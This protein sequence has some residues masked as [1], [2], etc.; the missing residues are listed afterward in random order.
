MCVPFN[1]RTLFVASDTP[2]SPPDRRL[3]IL[4]AEDSATNQKL[5]TR[6]LR[7]INCDLSIVEN[8]VLAVDQFKTSDFDVVLMDIHMP[9]LDGIEATRAIREWE[10]SVGRA[11]TP[12]IA[13][14]ADV[15]EDKVAIQFAAGIDYHV[16]KPINVQELL[17]TIQNAV[18]PQN[19]D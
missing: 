8:G 12:I 3:N 13:V 11:R 17:T 5:L 19:D 15:G 18:E 6:I 9:E 2:D 1:H 16:S 10:R 4:A 7:A 14:T